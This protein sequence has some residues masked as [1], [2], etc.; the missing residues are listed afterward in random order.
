M[1]SRHQTGQ[2]V[3]Q[4]QQ[5]NPH[6]RHTSVIYVHGMGEQRRYEEVSRL[7][8]ALDKRSRLRDVQ[9][10]LE[11]SRNEPQ[12]TET[13]IRASHYCPDSHS[14]TEARFYEVY[15]APIMNQ[16]DSAWRV[17]RWL[18]V[19]ILRPLQTSRSPWRERQ[20]LRRSVLAD[21][22]E[23]PQR[24]PAG[25]T[26]KDLYRLAR[27]YYLFERLD[28]HRQFAAGSFQDFLEFIGK[29]LAGK[30]DKLKRYTALARRWRSKYQRQELGNSLLLLTL[31]LALL[32][33][34]GT[35]VYLTLIFLQQLANWPLFQS[36]VDTLPEAA[37]DRLG[38]NLLTAASIALSLGSFLGLSRFLRSYMGDV[39]AWTTYQ[40]TTEKHRYRQQILENWSLDK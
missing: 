7:V 38:P 1:N 19:Q 28:A 34:A 22:A 35:A 2:S 26:V 18:F 17:L 27:Y 36:V 5:D 11:P 21:M 23:H 30:P 29:K 12:R 40:E 3:P 33:L 10:R 24:L 20:R 16:P 14:E 9:V 6:R 37:A 25:V 8:D 4:G 15:W 39:E 31:A 32:L 13:Y